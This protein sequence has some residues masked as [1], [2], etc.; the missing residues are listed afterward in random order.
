M[1]CAQVLQCTQTLKEG[2][3]EDAQTFLLTGLVYRSTEAARIDAARI[4][5]PWRKGC[6]FSKGSANIKRSFE[7]LCQEAHAISF[8]GLR[9]DKVLSGG[10]FF[11]MVKNLDRPDDLTA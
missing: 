3:W 9:E 5:V 10:P 7:R 2:S 6:V 4:G 11:A 1:S 8:C